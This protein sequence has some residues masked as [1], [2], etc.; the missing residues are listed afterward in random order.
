MGAENGK[1]DD[2]KLKGYIHTLLTSL[3]NLDWQLG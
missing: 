1:Q 3:W 2:I